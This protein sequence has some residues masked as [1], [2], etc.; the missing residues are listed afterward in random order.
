VGS[1]IGVYVI[2]TLTQTPNQAIRG[3][4]L[5]VAILQVGDKKSTVGL[6]NPGSGIVV[7]LYCPS[8]F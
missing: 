3:T 7:D 6:D 2:D 5:E 1:Y 8:S 4:V